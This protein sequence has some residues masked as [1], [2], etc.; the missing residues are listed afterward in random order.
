MFQVVNSDNAQAPDFGAEPVWKVIIGGNK[1]SRGY[2][3]EGLTISYYRRVARSADTVMQMGRWFGFRPGYRDLVRVFLGV[4]E[5]RDKTDLV[6]QFKEVCRLEERFR[7]EIRRYARKPDGKR[8]TPKQIPPL[9][10]LSGNLPP[11]SRNK[12]F[13]AVL[14]KKNFGGQRSMQT[15]VASKSPQLKQNVETVRRFLS[16]AA[17][18]GLNRLGGTSANNDRSEFSAVVF[19]AQNSSLVQFLECFR[20][21]ETEYPGAGDRPA[22]VNL[23]I[24]FLTK[25]DHGIE[26]WLVVAPQRT[27][28]FGPPLKLGA[29]PELSVKERHRSGGRGF[30]VFGEPDHRMTAEYLTGI[31]PGNSTLTKPNLETASRRDTHQGIVLL[32]LVR[33]NQAGEVSIGFELLFPRNNLPFELGFTVR[34]KGEQIKVEG[35]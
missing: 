4:E 7:E 23:Q 30:Q 35:S 21:L 27:K 20:W 29:L 18:Q 26:R 13:N 19:E 6:A 14:Q 31:E 25:E 34:R 1:L 3:I 28:S 32:Y 17:P 24:E 2:T 5:G 10:S 33:E 9:I 12:M 11:T 22:E 16:S 8:I 15:L